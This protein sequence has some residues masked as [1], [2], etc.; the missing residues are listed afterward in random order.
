MEPR[1]PHFLHFQQRVTENLQLREVLHTLNF[2]DTHE[3]RPQGL[4]NLYEGKEVEAFVI[5]G[6][7]ECVVECGELD[8]RYRRKHEATAALGAYSNLPDEAHEIV[9][10]SN[11]QICRSNYDMLIHIP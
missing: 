8:V 11:I 1:S 2:V 3:L 4:G 5:L 9:C 10:N 7:K 6:S